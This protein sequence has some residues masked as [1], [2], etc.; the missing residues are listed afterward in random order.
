MSHILYRRSRYVLDAL[1]YS[2]VYFAIAI[3]C[4]P[5]GCRTAPMLRSFA[6]YRAF[7]PIDALSS[8]HKLV[9]FTCDFDGCGIFSALDKHADSDGFVH[10]KRAE[11]ACS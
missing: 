6:L 1:Q 9:A 3:V 7:K 8:L 4:K 11:Y 2:P 10:A 5:G